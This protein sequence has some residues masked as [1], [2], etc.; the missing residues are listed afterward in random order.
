MI[1][2]LVFI[3]SLIRVFFL[4]EHISNDQKEIYRLCFV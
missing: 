3:L 4:V 2:L 1:L